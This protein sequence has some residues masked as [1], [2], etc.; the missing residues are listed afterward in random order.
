M[1]QIPV[2]RQIQRRQPI[3]VD[4]TGADAT[5]FHLLIEQQVAVIEVS[6][7]DAQD[8]VMDREWWIV[9]GGALNNAMNRAPNGGS[10][11]AAI[12][13]NLQWVVDT[14]ENT[15]GRK[16]QLIENGQLVVS[17]SPPFDMAI[18]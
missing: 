17:A 11:L 18:R 2:T 5:G 13:D 3:Q 14:V 12:V 6:F 16:E 7:Y 1:P 15:P 10:T 8:Q 4:L 9:R